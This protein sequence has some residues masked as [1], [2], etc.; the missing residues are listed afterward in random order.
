MEHAQ[1][2]ER[3]KRRV[4]IPLVVDAMAERPMQDSN[5]ALWVAS[6]LEGADRDAMAP[7]ALEEASRLLHG[8][9]DAAKRRRDERVELDLRGTQRP[10]QSVRADAE[11][12]GEREAGGCLTPG[13]ERALKAVQ[14]WETANGDLSRDQAAVLEAR[15]LA[16]QVALDRSVAKHTPPSAPPRP[17][18]GH[19]FPRTEQETPA[20]WHGFARASTLYQEVP[21]PPRCEGAPAAAAPPARPAEG[22]GV[23]HSQGRAAPRGIP[24]PAFD[25]QGMPRAN[26]RGR[27]DES[28]Q[29]GARHGDR[30]AQASD[31]A[32][33]DTAE[34]APPT[35]AAAAEVVAAPVSGIA[36]EAAADEDQQAHAALAILRT[37]ART[38][39]QLMRNPRKVVQSVV[40]ACPR[41]SEA[42]EIVEPEPEPEADAPG[43]ITREIQRALAA[44]AEA[45][46]RRR[47]QGLAVAMPDQES[48]V[49]AWTDLLEVAHRLTLLVVDAGARVQSYEAYDFLRIA[50]E[51]NVKHII[52][53][54]RF[55]YKYVK[56]RCQ[57][58]PVTRS[59]LQASSLTAASTP[60]APLQPG[61][62]ADWS[63]LMRRVH[64][65]CLLAGAP[66][67]TAQPG[68]PMRATGTGPATAFAAMQ[69]ANT[70]A[71]ATA[72]AQAS[73]GTHAATATAQA[74]AT[75][76]AQA[77]ATAREAAAAR[78]AAAAASATAPAPGG[79]PPQGASGNGGRAPDSAVL[80]LPLQQHYALHGVVGVDGPP[81]VPYSCM[82]A[83]CGAFGHSTH[84]PAALSGCKATE[85]ERL[86]R[87]YIRLAALHKARYG[88][89][90]GAPMAGQ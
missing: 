33:T 49:K 77:A 39:A 1:G 67:S 15:R 41:L 57:A 46:R 9:K 48:Y 88:P 54:P 28:R 35:R 26:L 10:R 14:A 24:H 62:W 4:A 23:D 79:A 81:M 73:A 11:A 6:T 68:A 53:D 27:F 38:S 75:A 8:A 3:Q 55:G 80:E 13:M 45:A 25:P 2:A 89:P 22:A 76:H 29:G 51:E 61:G 50:W 19:R 64:E 69:A 20:S 36:G 18:P 60:V 30:P 82:C 47:M 74:Q 86:Q 65:A 32:H 7:Q 17:P 78:A 71:A 90:A 63:A 83:A 43:P 85:V 72:R 52:A 84:T 16:A 59:S 70:A 44:E 40:A 58:E 12:A 56:D 87:N 42:L 5:A 21:A 37:A 31:G 34:A 66:D